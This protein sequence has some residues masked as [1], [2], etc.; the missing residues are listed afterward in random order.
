VSKNTPSHMLASLTNAIVEL[1]AFNLTFSY[2]YLPSVI[3]ILSA[4]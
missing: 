4:W 1:M 3:V 2:L